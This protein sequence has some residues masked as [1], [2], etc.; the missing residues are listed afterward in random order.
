VRQLGTHPHWGK[1]MDHDA[2]EIRVLRPL[3]SRFGELRDEIDP[4]NVFAKTSSSISS[5]ALDNR[6]CRSFVAPL[7]R[8]LGVVIAGRRHPDPLTCQQRPWRYAQGEIDNGIQ[9][10]EEK[11]K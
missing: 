8:C 3:T 11:L 2:E 4:T 1:E 9:L 5:S 10:G 7:R 6:F